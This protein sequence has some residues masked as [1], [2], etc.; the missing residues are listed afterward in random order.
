MSVPSFKRFHRI[1]HHYRAPAREE[2]WEAAVGVP[3][4]SF[5]TGNR[6]RRADRKGEKLEE[7]DHFLTRDAK[8]VEPLL[9]SSA[10]R[11]SDWVNRA[12]KKFPCYCLR[13]GIWYT[14]Q[15]YLLLVWDI[16]DLESV[17]LPHNDADIVIF[18]VKY[19]LP[20]RWIAENGKAF[21]EGALPSAESLSRLNPTAS[22][23]LNDVFATIMG[24]D[25]HT[26]DSWERSSDN[27]RERV[28]HEVYCQYKEGFDPMPSF[29]TRLEE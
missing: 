8:Q 10:D 20:V 9:V 18:S 26:S 14:K 5:L 7:N 4:S 12:H 2:L 17:G 27:P 24:A 3:V 25:Q 29:N 15:H 21:R 13:E 19:Y 6:V 1:T 22:L 28:I 11:S 16:K 23:S